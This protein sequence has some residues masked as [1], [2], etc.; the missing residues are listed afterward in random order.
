MRERAKQFAAE[1]HDGQTR[2]D[3][4]TPYITHTVG[5]AAI[6]RQYGG[7]EAQEAAAHLH[8]TIEDCDC[9]FDELVDTFGHAI[10]I[11]VQE[12]T[13]TSKIDRPDA[14]R[15][16]RKAMDCEKL[17]G[18]SDRTKLVKLADIYYNVND[19]KG[20]DRGFAVKFLEEKRIQAGVV[21]EGHEQLYV[22]IIESIDRNKERLLNNEF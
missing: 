3:G 20:L 8:D 4:V 16:Q 15:A 11:M 21:R 17:K 18:V 19:L 1:K 22:K 9:T 10:A 7:D 14:N 2:K 6:T 13:N 12:L 5:V